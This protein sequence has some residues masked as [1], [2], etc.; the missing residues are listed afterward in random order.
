MTL[1]GK[2]REVK[3]SPKKKKATSEVK[4]GLDLFGFIN[5]IYQD[6]RI[7]FFDELSDDD[8]KKYRYS[9]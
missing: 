4:S 6:Q 7:D 3:V 1:A 8:K 2:L 5:A 9:R